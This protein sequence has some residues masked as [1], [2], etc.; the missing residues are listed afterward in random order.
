MIQLFSQAIVSY[1]KDTWFF[2][3][4]LVKRNLKMVLLISYQ[5]FCNDSTEI[6]GFDPTSRDLSYPLFQNLNCIF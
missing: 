1:I 2:W 3:G 5:K 4:W 6:N